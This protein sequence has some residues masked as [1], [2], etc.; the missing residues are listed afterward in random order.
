M[1]ISSLFSALI[2]AAA[3]SLG[4]E[5]ISVQPSTLNVTDGQTFSLDIDIVNIT[6]L[7]AFQFD[8]GFDPT[9]LAAVSVTEGSFLPSGG[10]TIFF[11]G[12][13]DN[14]GGTIT[15]NADALVGAISGVSGSGTLAS[16]E[17]DAIGTGTSAIG[18]ANVFLLDSNLN[19][20][21]ASATNGE[22]TV[23]AATPEPSSLALICFSLLPLAG[24]ELGKRWPH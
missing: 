18:L 6:D 22:V 16:I 14:V 13:I 3:G 24:L 7:Y 21:T 5:T 1:R 12:T 23:S 9:I 17:F 11:P 2:F 19:S 8:I 15:S 4:A 20:I 10:S